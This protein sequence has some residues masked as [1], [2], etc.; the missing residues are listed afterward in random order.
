MLVVNRSELRQVFTMADAF[1]AVEDAARAWVAGSVTVPSRTALTAR[2]TG[3]EML[4]MPG[5]V[6]DSYAGT[7]VWYAAG[8]DP[9]R[10]EASAAAILLLDPELGE[11]LLNGELITDLRTGAMTGLAARQLAREGA[12]VLTIVG[13][14]IQAR[15]QALAVVH[16]LPGVGE[17]RVTSRRDGPREAFVDDLRRELSGSGREVVVRST[18]SAEEA[19]EGADV[20]VAATT[21]R[22]PV[23]DDRWV[24]DDTLVCGV[25]SHDPGAA[26]IAPDTVARAGVVVVDTKP[27]AIDGA[28]DVAHVID[29][30]RI[31]RDDVVELG[32]VVDGLPAALRGRGGP[33]V[34][35]TVGFA[36]ADLMAAQLA[37]RRAVAAGL[38]TQVFLR[39]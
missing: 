16:A 7:K 19:C 15:T 21:A 28:G 6:A 31:S 17:I 33:R 25:G 23:I 9:G 22:S 34:L 2:S 35:K 26:E 30:G 8:D 13:A 14:G 36:A 1:A 38:G 5:V 29:A 3:I 11:V 39:G 12:T 37:A 27:G 20:M 10:L 18:R 32:D 4:V 24:A